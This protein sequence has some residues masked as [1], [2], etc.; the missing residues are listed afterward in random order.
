MYGKQSN[1]YEEFV[2]EFCKLSEHSSGMQRQNAA[3]AA[4]REAKKQGRCEE[5]LALLKARVNL[6][7][8]KQTGFFA[9]YTKNFLEKRARKAKEMSEQ[10]VT[11]VTAETTPES[12][13]PV[14]VEPAPVHGSAQKRVMKERSLV[15][16]RSCNVYAVI[17]VFKRS[18]RNCMLS[19]ATLA[20]HF[21]QLIRTNDHRT[22]QLWR[23]PRLL[24]IM[25]CPE[26]IAG[27]SSIASHVL[28]TCSFR[29]D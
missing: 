12:S 19:R 10:K 8:S 2:N 29:L 25:C 27:V 6:R 22:L 23:L 18:T 21:W 15:E 13:E 11:S 16:V 24:R 20:A 26:H 4:W 9:N 7:K 14:P 28:R 3:N 1:L 17:V 5:E